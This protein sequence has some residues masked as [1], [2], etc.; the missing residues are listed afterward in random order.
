MQKQILI[1]LSEDEL[2]K[3]IKGS[4]SEAIKELK[5]GSDDKKEYLKGYIT[6]IVTNYFDGSFSRMATFFAKENDLD[7]GE[8]QELIGEIKS[9]LKKNEEH[10]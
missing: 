10:G 4:V 6:G 9:E 3:L 2:H 1:S 8:L 7:L 5:T